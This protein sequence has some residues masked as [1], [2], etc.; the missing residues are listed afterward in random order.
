MALSLLCA[1]SLASAD[2]AT[3]AWLGDFST[4]ELTLVR[5][6]L[7]GVVLSPLLFGMPPLG[8]LPPAFWGWIAILLPLEIAAMALYLAAIRDHPLSLTLPYLAFTPV[9]VSLVAFVLLGERVTPGGAA[10]IALVVAGA[11]LLNVRHARR[12]DWRSWAMP[13]RAILH[14]PGS[15]MML[16]VAVIYALTST[17]GKGAMQYLPAH[18]FGA[19]Y[20]AL[21][22]LATL[23]LFGLPQ[24]GRLRR[25]LGLRPGGRPWTVLVVV[26]LNALMIYTHFLALQ[27]VQV[28]YMISVKRVSLLFGILYG[29]LLFHE[30]GLRTQL[31]AGVLMLAG[32]FLI[33][34][35]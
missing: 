5:F 30:P 34:L 33:A 31:P 25:A 14:E 27:L 32:V 10:G 12:G 3:K 9:F 18:Y 21:L 28:A 8:D 6:T 13:L 2:A 11:W 19:F 1:L 29:A 4:R 17:L 15:R 20:F 24:P 22:G 23:V 16:A 26:G 7:T 35:A